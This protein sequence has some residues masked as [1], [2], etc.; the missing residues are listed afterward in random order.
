MTSSASSPYRVG[1]R[2]LNHSLSVPT[3]KSYSNRLLILAALAPGPVTLSA[4]SPSS[5]TQ[6]LLHCLQ[7]M[8][9]NIQQSDRDTTIVNSFPT[10]EPSSPVTLKTGDGGTTTRFLAA[11]AARGR[12]SYHFRPSGPMKN[13]PLR[14][15][16][17]ALE[18]R[19]VRITYG[20]DNSFEILGPCNLDSQEIPIDCS[21]TTQFASA[22]MLALADTDV[23]VRP[24]NVAS[25]RPYLD[26]TEQLLTEFS[27]SLSHYEIP[28]DFS[29][30][31]YPLALGM[32]C[33]RVVIENCHELDSSQADHVIIPIAH[34]MNAH[35]DWT[36]QGLVASKSAPLS[37]IGRNV[38]DCPDL[39]PTLAFLASYAEGTSQ[40]TGLEILRHKESDRICEILNILKL[41]CVPHT[42][43]AQKNELTIT[44]PAPLAPFNSYNAPDDHRM[45]MTAYLFMRKNSGGLLSNTHQVAKSFPNFFEVMG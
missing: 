10:C 16:L 1:N 22:L 28:P 12:Q 40:L 32:T 14:E 25:S 20:E 38:S 18:K 8:G 43:C 13:R 27:P 23:P 42:F 7:K 4:L 37:P 39:V 24:L 21:R 19:E 11:L 29:S 26:L 5:D 34:E 6:T 9:L 30:L 15:L 41:F 2:P 45:I 31:S 33:E 17:N 36:E 35:I 3:S 44:G